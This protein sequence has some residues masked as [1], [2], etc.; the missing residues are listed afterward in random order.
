MWIGIR[1]SRQSVRIPVPFL[2]VD[3][4]LSLTLEK[5]ALVWYSS[6]ITTGRAGGLNL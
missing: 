2:K 5:V 6:H 1:E 4:V 3:Q